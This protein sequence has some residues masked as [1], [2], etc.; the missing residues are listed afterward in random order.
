MS[1]GIA[2]LGSILMTVQDWLNSDDADTK[3]RKGYAH[4]DCR[5]GIKDQRGYILNPENI[6]RHGF[7]PF[8][9]Y[10]KKQIKY[11]K[12]GGRKTKKRDI[13]YAAHIDRCIYQYYSFLLGELYN[14][15]VALDGISQVAVAYRTDLH[16]NNIDFAK[17]AISF[18]RSNSSCYIMIGD[19]T[20]FFDNLDHKYL[21]QQWCSLMGVTTLPKDH[22]KVF[23][24]VTHYST[25]ELTDLLDLN[26][27]EDNRA[28]RRALNS[29]QRVLTPEEYKAN[30]NR[31]HIQVN[32]NTYGIPQGSPISGL[33]A[34]VYMLEVDRTINNLVTD[35]KGLYMRYSDDFI[36]VIPNT[37]ALADQALQ[38]ISTRFNTVAGL[39]LEPHKTQYFKFENQVLENCGAQFGIQAEGRKQVVNFL[40]FTFDGK[41]VSIRA[42]TVGKYY[43]RMYGKAK[44]IK[45]N[46]GYSP[47]GNRISA[48]NLYALYSKKG[49]HGY[50]IKQKDGTRKWHSGNF[51][52]Y[53]QR[54]KRKFGKNELIDRDTHRHMQKIK[55]AL[56][57]RKEQ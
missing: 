39:T 53:V 36:V 57:C 27:L 31:K 52:S 11:S 43:Y 29:Q 33:L 41:K 14:Q 18:I 23:R 55:K 38:D 47:K 56:K 20:G 30:S 7:Y 37:G 4:F 13:C 15:R 19:F 9:H 24:S 10:E 2:I 50:Q 3:S 5:T 21:K 16:Q 42:K 1:A 44:T 54:A 34:N 48:E 35:L 26:H 45:R 28:G 6:A 17:R 25:W 22:Y 40:G 32:L 51:I 49:A 12:N 8:I 46:K